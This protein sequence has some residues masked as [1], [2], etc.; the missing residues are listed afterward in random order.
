[1]QYDISLILDASWCSPRAGKWRFDLRSYGANARRTAR[2]LGM[3]VRGGVAYLTD[4][5]CDTAER[6]LEARG[7]A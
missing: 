6:I 1:M 3:V 2:A 5:T 7:I 4:S